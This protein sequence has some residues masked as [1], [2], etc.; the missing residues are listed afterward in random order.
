MQLDKATRRFLTD[1]A[2]IRAKNPNK[3][4]GEVLSDLSL[5]IDSNDFGIISDEDLIKATDDLVKKYDSDLRASKCGDELRNQPI[6]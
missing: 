5:A 4:I 2:L 3:T 6:G 1:L